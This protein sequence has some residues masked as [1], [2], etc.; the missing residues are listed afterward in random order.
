MIL[1]LE[2]LLNCLGGVRCLLFLISSLFIEV[3][4]NN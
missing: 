4:G 2:M 3:K 1:E